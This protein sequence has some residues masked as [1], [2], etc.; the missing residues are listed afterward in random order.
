LQS[1]VSLV[2]LAAHL[3][4]GQLGE[5]D[6]KTA[7]IVIQL[8]NALGAVPR[9]SPR[10]RRIASSLVRRELE[11]LEPE[12]VA[13]HLV[14]IKVGRPDDLEGKIGKDPEPEPVR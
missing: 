4:V 3:G 14:L 7:R 8:H 1:A 13:R 5:L 9:P 6:R 11:G 12:Q 10:A 2:S